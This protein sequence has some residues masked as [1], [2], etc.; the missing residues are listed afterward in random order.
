MET[1]EFLSLI[2]LARAQTLYIHELVKIVII[3]KHK[4]FVF[5]AF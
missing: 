2:D 4:Y 1:K 3:S 5:S